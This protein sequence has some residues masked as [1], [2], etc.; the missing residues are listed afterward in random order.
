M[1]LI[2]G[3]GIIST[4]PDWINSNPN[5]LNIYF[6]DGFVYLCLKFRSEIHIVRLSQDKWDLVQ[7][8]SVLTRIRGLKEMKVM[9]ALVLYHE[10]RVIAFKQCNKWRL[11]DISI[12]REG[13]S[14]PTSNAV[15]DPDIIKEFDTLALTPHII[16]EQLDWMN[17]NGWASVSY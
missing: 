6:K 3:S 7:D 14:T 4:D 12:L 2:D 10:A 13:V 11:K 1:K 9:K 16:D 5:H 15:T 8:N 17:E